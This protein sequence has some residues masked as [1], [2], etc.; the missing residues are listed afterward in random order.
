MN[1]KIWANNF[2][3]LYVCRFTTSTNGF[4]A[5]GFQNTNK[6]DRDGFLVKFSSAGSPICSSYFGTTYRDR[7]S[8]VDLDH[9]GNLYLSGDTESDSGIATSG[10]HQTSKPGTQYGCLLMKV[11]DNSTNGVEAYNAVGIDARVYPN[12]A[13]GFV[14]VDIGENRKAWLTLYNIAG[15]SLLENTELVNRLN[16]IDLTGYVPGVYYIVLRNRSG[17]TQTDEIVL[18]SAQK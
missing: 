6:G 3:S 14:T 15:Q 9:S 10:A 2:G 1:K 12:P 4:G 8:G 18:E 7:L 16:T 5:G 17:G 11:V 13:K